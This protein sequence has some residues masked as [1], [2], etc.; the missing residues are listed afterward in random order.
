M[1]ANLA[2]EGGVC[3]GW[4]PLFPRVLQHGCLQ[5][6]E[7]NLVTNHLQHWHALV[8]GS[9]EAISLLEY[10]QQMAEVQ[11]D[12]GLGKLTK[13]M[14]CLASMRSMSFFSACLGQHSQ[15]TPA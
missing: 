10:S 7:L 5:Q 9:R 14:P 12:P 3:R 2:V 6:V 8:I 1:S 4:Q 13:V 15:G 11:A